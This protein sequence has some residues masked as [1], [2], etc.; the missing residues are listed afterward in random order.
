MAWQSFVSDQIL[1]DI[2]KQALEIKLNN[3]FIQAILEEIKNRKLPLPN[4]EMMGTTTT[5]L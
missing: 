1:L 2:Y 4:D 5:H 3:E